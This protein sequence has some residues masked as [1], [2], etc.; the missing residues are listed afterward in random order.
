[1][2]TI[3]KLSIAGVFLGSLMTF[4]SVNAA[5]SWTYS[6]GNGMTCPATGCVESSTMGAKTIDSTA[7]G[8]YSDTTAGATIQQANKL[9]VWDGLA[10]EATPN[11]TQV[12][13]HATDNNTWYDS[14]LF[15]FGS[16][17]VALDQ[18][19]MGWR[20]DSD[21]S[22]LRYTGNDTPVIA[23]QSYSDLNTTGGWELV[24]NYFYGGNTRTGNDL[25][26]NVNPDNKSSSYWLVAALNPAYFNNSNY[27]G[28]DYFKIK[29]LSGAYDDTCTVNCNPPCQGG[30]C[31]QVPAPG[32]MALLLLG[33]PLLRIARNKVKAEKLAA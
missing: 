27:I 15:D 26:F 19:V 16:D 31:G 9:R 8:W 7:T 5:Y 30:N 23:G 2:K 6:G 18:I 32:S 13:Q 4:Q 14:V 28:N 1:M 24:D 10:V 29:T 25:T 17:K 22:L 20:E 33:L 21:F 3:K 11:D 12:P